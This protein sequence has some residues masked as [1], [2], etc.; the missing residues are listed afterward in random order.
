VGVLTG[1]GIAK[2][3]E[4]KRTEMESLECIV[5]R[6]LGTIEAGT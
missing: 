5:E 1:V 4:I 2:T 6:C 3:V